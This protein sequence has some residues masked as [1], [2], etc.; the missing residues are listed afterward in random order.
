[1]LK[2]YRITCAAADINTV[3]RHDLRGTAISE[4]EKMIA[5]ALDCYLWEVYGKSWTIRCDWPLWHIVSRSSDGSLRH[6]A[7]TE[8][9]YAPTADKALEIYLDEHP[10]QRKW[11]SQLSAELHPVQDGA[12][13]AAPY[14][15][16][17]PVSPDDCGR[18]QISDGAEMFSREID[19]LRPA[20][21]EWLEDLT[22]WGHWEEAW[23]VVWRDGPDGSPAEAEHLFFRAEEAPGIDWTMFPV[24][25]G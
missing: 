8:G 12:P 13:E 20:R 23:Y 18:Y 3:I 10:D 15:R 21:L 1:M 6:Y 14:G 22:G 7:E 4:A 2:P 11:A 25:S 24:A 16:Y 17:I 9:V 5:K 19:E